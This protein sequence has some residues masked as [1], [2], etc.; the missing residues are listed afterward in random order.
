MATNNVI[1]V[2]IA[3]IMRP[4]GLVENATFNALNAPVAIELAA[5][6]PACASDNAIP[7]IAASFC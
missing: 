6:T 4:K 1:T 2:V 5:A 7:C 3:V